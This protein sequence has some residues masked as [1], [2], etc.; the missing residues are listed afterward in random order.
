[1]CIYIY[2]FLGPEAWEDLS[3]PTGDQTH[4]PLHWKVKS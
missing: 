2:I 3:S 1:M 4:I